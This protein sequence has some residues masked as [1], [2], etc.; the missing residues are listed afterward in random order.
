[1]TCS[2]KIEV[3]MLWE[4]AK[5]TRRKACTSVSNEAQSDVAHQGRTMRVKQASALPLKNKACVATS[6]DAAAGL[7]SILLGL[8][9]LLNLPANELV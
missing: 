2:K 9:S 7:E 8:S 5:H 1:M 4:Q 3:G 6:Y